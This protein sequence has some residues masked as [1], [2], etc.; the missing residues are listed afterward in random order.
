MARIT[1]RAVEAVEPTAKPVLLWD[2]QL[3]GFGVKVLPNGLRRYLVKY[4]AG[5]GG[6]AAAQRWYM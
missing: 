1:K 5:G 2:D 3:P 6:R 4:R